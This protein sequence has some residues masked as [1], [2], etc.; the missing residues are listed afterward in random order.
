MPFYLPVNDGNPTVEAI[1]GLTFSGSILSITGDI[2]SS[3]DLIANNATINE[4]FVTVDGAST[5][6][7]FELKRDS[8][9]TYKI[10]HLDGGLTIQ[11]STDNRKEMS[12]DG[13]GNVG[14]GTSSPSEKLTVSGSLKIRNSGDT[15]LIIDSQGGSNDDSIIDFRENSVHRALVYFDGNQNDFVISSSIGDFHLLPAGN[16]GIGTTTP[17]EKLTVEGNISASGDI[18]AS[19]ISS[20]ATGSFAQLSLPNLPTSDPGIAGRLFTTQSTGTGGNLEGQ[21]VLLVSVG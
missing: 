6:H 16:V 15:R 10:R 1:S 11:N 2:S 17:G 12:F 19:N 9:D 8:L 7:G 13:A 3:G 5:S 18:T 20:S 14:I 21:L 4:G